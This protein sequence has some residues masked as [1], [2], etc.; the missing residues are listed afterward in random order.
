MIA[1]LRKELEELA[2][3]LLA[4]LAGAVVWVAAHLTQSLPTWSVREA[5]GY[6][7]EDWTMFA[8]LLA[9]ASGHSRVGPEFVHGTIHFM[10]GLPTS[11]VRMFAVKLVAGALPVALLLAVTVAVKG[12]ALSAWLDPAGG[13]V[14]LVT[15]WASLQIGLLL[16]ACYGAGLFLSWFGAMGWAAFGSFGFGMLF[17]SVIS[18]GA[19]AWFPLIWGVVDLVWVDGWPVTRVGPLLGWAFTGTAGIGMSGL[20]FLGPGDRLVKTGSAL[21]AVFRALVFA[22]P[23]CILVVFGGFSGLAFLVTLPSFFE[24]TFRVDTEHFRFLGQRAHEAEV[25]AVIDASE[26]YRAQLVTLFEAP[27]PQRVDVEMTGSAEHFAGLALYGKVQLAP[28]E[29]PATLVHELSHAFSQELRHGRAN[30]D[31]WRFFEEGLATWVARDLTGDEAGLPSAPGAWRSGQADWMLLFEDKRR[32]ER[33][34]PDQVYPLGAIWAEAVAEASGRA[35]TCVVRASLD[36]PNHLDGG[37]QWTK[38]LSGCGTSLPAVIAAYDRLL[39]SD[40]GPLPESHARVW[41]EGSWLYLALSGDATACRVRSNAKDPRE[42]YGVYEATDGRCDLWR[43][44]LNS[45]S[46]DLQLGTVLE[47]GEPPSWGPWH[48]VVIP[49]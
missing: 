45:S 44:T 6:L 38:M 32:T 15:A 31:A 35:P 10:E 7:L 14:A 23:G 11:R 4:V 5:L 12:W 42:Q 21:A 17:L 19:R 28:A 30:D 22:A 37:P 48:T 36:L 41:R 39:Q 26:G 33:F 1:L 13:S 34:D 24:P 18:P 43:G 25:R 3:L 20:L 29:S 8:C 9:F 27:G 16:Y 46:F 49:P 47:P 2:P 40:A